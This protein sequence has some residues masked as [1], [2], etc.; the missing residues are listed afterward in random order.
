L[1]FADWQCRL[2]SEASKL[3]SRPSGQTTAIDTQIELTPIAHGKNVVT[4]ILAE[5]RGL[6]TMGEITVIAIGLLG[7]LSLLRVGRLR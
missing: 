3:A 4:V 6:D 1:A 5:F 7:I 2:S